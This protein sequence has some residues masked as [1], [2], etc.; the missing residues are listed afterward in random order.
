MDTGAYFTSFENN[1]S[2][3]RPAHVMADAGG[4]YVIREREKFEDM[5]KL[6]NF[7]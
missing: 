4:Y 7:Q 5:I 1:F 2:F 6:D 3:P